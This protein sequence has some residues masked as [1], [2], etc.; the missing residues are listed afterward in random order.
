MLTISPGNRANYLIFGWNLE[1]RNDDLPRDENF[2]VGTPK[3]EIAARLREAIR[4]AG[5]NQLVAAKS[6]VPLGT[7]NNMVRGVTEPKAAALG[8]LAEACGVSLDWLVLDKPPLQPNQS[9]SEPFLRTADLAA[10]QR[11]KDDF[12]FLPRYAARAAAGSGQLAVS[13]EV[14]ETLAFRRDWLRRIGVNPAFAFLLV[15][16]GDSM[17]PTIPD[18]ALML[19]DGSIREPADIRNGNI[20]VIVRTGMVIVKR[21]QFRIDDSVVLISDNPIYERETIS[22]ADMNDLQF[23]GR[24][25]WIGRTI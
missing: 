14:S 1:V 17:H 16:E 6:G 12:A 3:S 20:Y 10:Q 23:A 2:G 4:A 24:V 22:R 5:G 8:A 19:V 21:V 7:L 25:H 18:G 13:D 9:Q 15:A 11:L